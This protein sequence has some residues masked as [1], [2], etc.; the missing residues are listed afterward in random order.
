M[1]SEY[2]NLDEH[3]TAACSKNWHILFSPAMYYLAIYYIDM[4][5]L[6]IILCLKE[7]AVLYQLTFT[8][9]KLWLERVRASS[10]ILTLFVINSCIVLTFLELIQVVHLCEK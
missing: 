10:K 8:V 1:K 2:E 5:Y 3:T 6:V 7:R 9:Q 4:Y